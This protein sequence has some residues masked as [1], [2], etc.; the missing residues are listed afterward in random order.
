MYVIDEQTTVQ[1]DD[2]TDADEVKPEDTGLE[3]GPDTGAPEN[4][5]SSDDDN[6]SEDTDSGDDQDKD[7][8]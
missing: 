3:G 1:P 4:G 8:E 2:Q 5:D 6:A 7:S